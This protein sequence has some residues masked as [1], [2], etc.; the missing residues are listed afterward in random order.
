MPPQ[1]R[2]AAPQVN[3][4]WGEPQAQRDSKHQECPPS[5]ARQTLAWVTSSQLHP[6]TPLPVFL[7]AT[8]PA[9]WPGPIPRA[10]PAQD[11][12]TGPVL[13]SAAKANVGSHG[14][15]PW[16]LEFHSDRALG[17]QAEHP[18]L[19]CCS[20]SC[21][22]QHPLSVALPPALPP[23]APGPTPWHAARN[24]PASRGLAPHGCSPVAL[25]LAEPRSALTPRPACC[26]RGCP[27]SPCPS[28]LW[29]SGHGPEPAGIITLGG[30]RPRA[31]GAG[32]LLLSPAS[33]GGKRMCYM[34]SS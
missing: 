32:G 9:G 29:Q 21:V 4:A 33:W 24:P 13:C 7:E 30:C 5:P 27:L 18:G 2:G 25:L 11:G 34:P 6:R 14:R 19:S 3:P 31:P 8:P 22:C 15:R 1:G 17:A 10:R 28:S 16:P 12:R 23:G 26:S 20:G